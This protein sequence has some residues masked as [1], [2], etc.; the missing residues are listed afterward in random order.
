MQGTNSEYGSPFLVV[1]HFTSFHYVNGLFGF[2]T[3]I[4]RVYSELWVTVSCPA[5]IH[6]LPDHSVCVCVCVCSQNGRTPLHLAAHKGHIAVVKILLA[7]GCDLDIQDDVSITCLQH[8][9]F[10]AKITALVKTIISLVITL[11][12]IAHWSPKYSIFLVVS[13]QNACNGCENAENRTWSKK[14]YDERKFQTL[15]A[16]QWPL[17]WIFLFVWLVTFSF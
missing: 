17:V 4:C 3:D 9:H 15:C 16:L 5:N 11:K 8:F 1:C 7:A 10:W 13:Y 14:C 2:I 12:V 6:R